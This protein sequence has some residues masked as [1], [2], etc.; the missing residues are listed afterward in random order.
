LKFIHVKNHQDNAT[1]VHLLAARMNV[2]ADPSTDY[3]DNYAQSSKII[4]FIQP[5]Q[6]SL[7]IDGETITEDSTDHASDQQPELAQ[8]DL[9]TQTTGQQ[10]S[11]PS[12]GKSPGKALAYP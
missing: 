11:N 9:C 6:A 12:T 7:T 4:P 1:A 10:Y 8:Q 5:S 2:Q 3:L